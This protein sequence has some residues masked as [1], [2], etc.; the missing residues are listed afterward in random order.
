MQELTKYTITSF[1]YFP[2][3]LLKDVLH[4]NEKTNQEGRQEIQQSRYTKVSNPCKYRRES[5]STQT[6]VKKGINGT[7]LRESTKAM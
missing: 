7:T 2:W 3:L 1:T 5:K 4:N 6:G